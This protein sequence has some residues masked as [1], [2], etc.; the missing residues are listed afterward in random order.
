MCIRILTQDIPDWKY[1][2]VLGNRKVN[3][4]EQNFQRRL[5][6]KVYTGSLRML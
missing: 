2:T 6:E 1:V 3:G 5:R 4:K